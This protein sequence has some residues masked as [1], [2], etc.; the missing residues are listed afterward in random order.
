M[1]RHWRTLGLRGRRGVALLTV[2]MTLVL[3]ATLAAVT[4]ASTGAQMH[5]LERGMRATKARWQVEGCAAVGLATLNA[6]LAASGTAAWSNLDSVLLHS[7]IPDVVRGCELRVEATGRVLAATQ[8]DAR[9]LS[10]L[11]VE[12]GIGYARAESLSSALMDWMDADD[13]ARAGGAESAWYLGEHRAP[14]GN[15]GLRSLD[16]LF[17]VRGFDA[18][19]LIADTVSQLLGV[20]SVRLS[21]R[22]ASRA[23]LRAVPG[24]SDASAD[25]LIRTRR[26]PADVQLMRE[27]AG[28]TQSAARLLTEVPD[29]WELVAQLR[30]TSGGTPATRRLWLGRTQTRIAVLR[31]EESR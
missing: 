30:E 22:Y 29:S 8:H 27:T 28:Q 15:S 24:L 14:P 7:T 6:S 10:R 26:I 1:T 23:V 2:M 13:V 31:V 9:S 11:F 21:V 3:I 12:G 17:L 19:R 4:R 25:E 5:A 16:E 18:P 20:D